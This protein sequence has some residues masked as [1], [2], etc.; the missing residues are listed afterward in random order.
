MI[1]FLIDQRFKVN[2]QRLYVSALEDLKMYIKET[3]KKR[4]ELNYLIDGMVIKINEMD[5]REELGYTEKFPRWAIAFKFAA[6]EVATI[7][8]EVSWEI[9]RTGKLTPLAHVEAVDIGGVTV[10]RCTLN[11]WGDIGR[12]S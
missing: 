5:V 8:K 7:L 11:N 3:E 9:G 1:Q 6:E 2:Q 12:L 10:Q 4:G